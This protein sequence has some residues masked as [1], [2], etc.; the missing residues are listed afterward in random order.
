MPAFLGSLRPHT[1][2]RCSHAIEHRFQ[3]TGAAPDDIATALLQ[4]R[5]NLCLNRLERRGVA[6][7]LRFVVVRVI[8][9]HS[10]GRGVAQC[11]GRLLN[12]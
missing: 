5:P 3:G 4:H 7:M 8:H 10:P 6:V 1:L 2:G 12:K 9:R 11:C